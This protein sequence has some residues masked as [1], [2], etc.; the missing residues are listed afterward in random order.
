[1]WPLLLPSAVGLPYRLLQAVH[2]LRQVEAAPLVG[3]TTYDLVQIIR[4]LFGLVKFNAYEALAADVD[5][6][7]QITIFDIFDINGGVEIEKFL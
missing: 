6:D 5:C 3:V 7:D 2:S 1:M 4:K